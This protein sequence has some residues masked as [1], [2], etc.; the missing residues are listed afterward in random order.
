MDRGSED[1]LILMRVTVSISSDFSARFLAPVKSAAS[2]LRQINML[3]NS[4]AYKRRFPSRGWFTKQIHL[5][6]LITGGRLSS[7]P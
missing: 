6:I 2:P 1:T 7:L 5:S 3:L 4:I